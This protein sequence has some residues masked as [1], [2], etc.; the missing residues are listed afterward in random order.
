[1]RT[2]AAINAAP[3]IYHHLLGKKGYYYD[4]YTR[5]YEDEATAKIL[6]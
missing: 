5:Q 4:L 6:A 3:V 2:G 1:M